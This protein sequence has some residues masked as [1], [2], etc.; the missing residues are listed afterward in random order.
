VDVN[1]TA[2]PANRA[3]V[4]NY[5]Y[6]FGD[7]STNLVTDKNPVEYTFAKDGTFKVSLKVNFT[8]DGQTKTSAEICEA[9][10]TFTTPKEIPN[11]G[12]GSIIGLL[13][14]TTLVG[15]VMHRFWTIRQTR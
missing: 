7:G 1:K 5:E 2:T 12:A 13:T 10:V 15:A 4:K 9:V 11:T 3:S 6:N 14:A 8:V